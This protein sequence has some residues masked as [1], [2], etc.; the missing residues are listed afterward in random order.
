[1]RVSDCE[2]VTTGGPFVEAKE[3]LGGFYIIE[4]ADLDAALGWASKVT[5]TVS[6]PIG[7]GPSRAARRWAGL[8]PTWN[9]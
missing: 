6:A 1:M 8:F 7:S 5:S 9:D 2:V 4:A 3:N